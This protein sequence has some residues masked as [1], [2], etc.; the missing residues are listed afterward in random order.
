MRL[1]DL[2]FK[3]NS[4]RI[5]VGLL[6]RLDSYSY[7][8]T[9]RSL[10]DRGRGRGRGG[11]VRDLWREGGRRFTDLGRYGPRREKSWEYSWPSV[12]RPWP[13]LT[14][15]ET[16]AVGAQTLANTDRRRLRSGLGLW[17]TDP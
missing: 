1:I 16:V 3:T 9:Y 15:E 17:C 8:Y 4:Y 14:G 6:V 7:S 10:D 2:R 12:H 5:L 13:S 11:K